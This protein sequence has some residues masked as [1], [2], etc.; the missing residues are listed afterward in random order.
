VQRDG[1]GFEFR[2]L[3][4]AVNYR[5]RL[6]EE[7]RPWI[8]GHVLEVGAGVGQITSLLRACPALKK[9]VA[10]EPDIEFATEFRTRAPDVELINGTVA[11]PGADRAWDAI[12]SVNVL[13]HIEGD[14]AELQRYH[15][16]LRKTTGAL[17]LFVPAGPEIFAPIDRDFGHFRRYTRNELRRKLTRT[18]F[19][20]TRLD[21]F[22]IVGYF[23]WWCTFC[24]LKRRSF[25]AGAVRFFDR[26]IFPLANQME[27]WL[28]P[29]F[30]QSLLAV[31]VPA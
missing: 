19:A 4:E 8:R 31:A 30:G 29:P 9:L 12:V 21:Y 15:Q 26:R 14:D 28:R 6:V 10:I 13:E 18:G 2:A 22:N 25:S 23:A 27:R 24:L 17:C 3:E 11:A 1:S 5:R 16:L 7:F 20:I